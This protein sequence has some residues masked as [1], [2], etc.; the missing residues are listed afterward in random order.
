[1][2]SVGQLVALHRENSDKQPL[3]GRRHGDDINIV[4]LKDEKPLPWKSESK[5][6]ARNYVLFGVGES[7]NADICENTA[8]DHLKNDLDQKLEHR[9]QMRLVLAEPNYL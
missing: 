9:A 7:S 6:I 4:W 5:E 2:H 1:M 8:I 3:V